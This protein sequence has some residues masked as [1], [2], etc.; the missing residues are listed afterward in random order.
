MYRL[1]LELTF[2][3]DPVLWEWLQRIHNLPE[4]FLHGCACF[5]RQARVKQEPG[6][7]AETLRCQRSHSEG[8]GPTTLPLWRPC[9]VALRPEATGTPGTASVPTPSVSQQCWE[10]AS[11]ASFLISFFLGI[12]NIC[13]WESGAKC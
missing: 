4:N 8:G 6:R 2:P 1:P 10:T 11:E 7:S 9:G 13:D 3:E 5:L 12:G